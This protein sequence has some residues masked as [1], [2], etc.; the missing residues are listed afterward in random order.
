[1][2]RSGYTEDSEMWAT[3]RWRGAVNSAIRGK[4][5]QAFL[6]EMLAALDALPEKR[7]ISNDL[8]RLSSDDKIQVCAIGS[9]GVARGIDMDA[10]DPEDSETVAATF[11]IPRA[12]AKEISF[13]NDE[14]LSHTT[15]P[16]TRFYYIR[17]W[18][19]SLIRSPRVLS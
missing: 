14:M 17:R 18:V 6:K 1:M 10:I 9:V 8:I 11:N 15:A 7:L 4:R 16:E 13:H 19:E 2:S 5:G 12:L 3:I